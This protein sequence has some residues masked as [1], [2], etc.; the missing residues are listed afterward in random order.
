MENP[1]KRTTI[2]TAT[3]GDGLHVFDH[4][5]QQTLLVEYDVS[6]GVRAL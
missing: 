5:Q 4:Q 3:G 6:P 1:R 2:T